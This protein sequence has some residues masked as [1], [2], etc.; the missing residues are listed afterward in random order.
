MQLIFVLA[1]IRIKIFLVNLFEVVEIIRTLGVHA[2]VNDEMLTVF[3]THQSVGAIGALKGKRPGKTV[4]IR[5]EQGSADFAQEL[6]GFAVIAVEI[7]LWCFTGGTG[8]FLR[9]VAF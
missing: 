2:L 8:T 7:R 3:L 5:R 1:V 9:D 6:T 4:F